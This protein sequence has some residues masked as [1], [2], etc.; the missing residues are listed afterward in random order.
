[1]NITSI[2]QAILMPL[3]H[4]RNI[5]IPI[6]GILA[7]CT[8]SHRPGFSSILTSAKVY[9]DMNTNENDDIIKKFVYNVIDKIKLN[10]QADAVCMIAIPP[11]GIEYILTGGNVLG[12]I[13]FSQDSED[14]KSPLTNKDFIFVWGIIR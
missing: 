11:G 13:V 7:L 2:I 3:E 8:A 4:V 1:M 6:P 9:A 10:L 5:L 14:P 12:P